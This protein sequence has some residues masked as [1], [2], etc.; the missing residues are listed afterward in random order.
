MKYYSLII[1]TS[2]VMFLLTGNISTTKGNEDATCLLFD[3]ECNLG[4][5]C[6]QVGL[7]KSKCVKGCRADLNCPPGYIC[8]KGTCKLGCM[9]GWDTGLGSINCSEGQLCVCEKD[10]LNGLQCLYN[11]KVIMDKSTPLKNRCVKPCTATGLQCPEG[12]TCDKSGTSLGGD[13]Y[14]LCMKPCSQD[15]ECGEKNYCSRKEHAVKGFCAQ[16]GG[17]KVEYLLETAS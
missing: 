13:S 17:V 5:I 2:M 3:A 10:K 6:K 14:G 15:S 1:A 4:L 16:L 8:D 7:F 9:V 12:Y 11:E